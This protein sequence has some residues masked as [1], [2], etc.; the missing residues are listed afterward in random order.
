MLNNEQILIKIMQLLDFDME[1]IKL[2]QTSD[3]KRFYT[4]EES[5]TKYKEHIELIFK[6]LNLDD[7]NKKLVDIF[8]DLL[9]LYNEIYQKLLPYAQVE[10]YEKKLNWM[11]LKRLVIPFLAF[12]FAKLD[13]TYEERIDKNM[14]GGLFW[15]LPDVRNYK[16]I[17]MP[18]NYL[19]DWWLDLYGKGLSELCNEI[20]NSDNENRA[21]S[22]SLNTLKEWKYK[23]KLPKKNTIL[24][25]LDTTIKYFGIFKYDKDKNIQEGYEEVLDFI[26]KKKKIS[27]EDLKHEIPF[28]SLVDEIFFEEKDISSSDKKRFVKFIE[29]RWAKPSKDS[30]KTKFIIGR[31]VHKCY[32][33]LLSYFNFKNSNDIEE[34]KN[35]Q[36]IHLYQT[37]YNIQ[38][39][40][41][42]N[43][44]NDFD[45]FGELGYE[46]LGPFYTTNINDI[47]NTIGGD[48]SIEYSNPNID[49]EVLEDIYPIKIGLFIE[50][51]D[52]RVERS[53]I[54]FKDYYKYFHEYYDNVDKGFKSYDNLNENDF[55]KNLK[56]ENDFNVLK[57]V[58]QKNILNYSRISLICRRMTTVANNIDDE[59]HT[60]SYILTKNT[61]Y[62]FSEN[63]TLFIETEHL[64][65]VYE[66]MLENYGRSDVKKDEV[67]LCK[68]YFYLKAKDFTTSLSFFDEYFKNF[69]LNQKKEEQ[70]LPIIYC[71]AYCSYTIKDKQKLKNYNKYL[72][73]MNLPE[74]INKQSLPFPIYFYK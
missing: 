18:I 72:Q 13:H 40:R 56:N 71:A 34:N 30:L 4:R 69:I 31:A 64:L 39:Q 36:L 70:Y 7:Q 47:I 20:D 63:T 5:N 27:P 45:V 65:T 43:G 33:D 59:Q 28:N 12:N 22:G 35:I 37:L 2:K 21:E 10:G 23:D 41:L 17:K 49:K 73:K 32:L 29:E 74:F 3:K 8:S 54:E 51:K 6:S 26:N 53:M 16:N 61:M 25:Y 24:N 46:M 19:M 60:I 55:E 68:G 66:K 48:I 58:F 62:Y 50:H 67:L 38:L 52:K 14:P 11:I 57:N 9:F 42:N 15:Y 44:N 1:D